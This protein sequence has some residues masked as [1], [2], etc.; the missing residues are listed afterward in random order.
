V[1]GRKNALS[2]S[3]QSVCGGWKASNRHERSRRSPQAWQAGGATLRGRRDLL[4]SNY[5]LAES[6]ALSSYREAFSALVRRLGI[7]LAVDERSG[8]NH[9]REA[10]FRVGTGPHGQRRR[11]A[12]VAILRN[13]AKGSAP[14]P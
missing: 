4:T 7:G 11:R 14:E 10:N 9:H 1:V 13:I 8:G 2:V 3:G 12:Y 6:P 5:D